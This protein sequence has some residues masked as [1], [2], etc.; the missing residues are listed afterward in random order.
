MIKF[1][2]K[3]T[4]LAFHKDQVKKYG[5]VQGIRDEGLLESA[6]AQPQASFD[7]KYVHETIFEMAAAYGFH[8]CK[9]HPFFDGNK[10]IALV[11]M[12]TFL[13][14]NDYQLKAD[15]KSLYAM[16]L[17]LASGK[18]EK[19]ELTGYIKENTIKRKKK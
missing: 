3:E 6:L 14:V 17:D 18:L 11:A 13:Y 5:G 12:Y 9:N 4:I 1:L 15:K 7:G 8:I 19:E 2:S 16:M 10:R